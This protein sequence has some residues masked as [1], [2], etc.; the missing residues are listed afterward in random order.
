[1]RGRPIEPRSFRRPEARTLEVCGK[2]VG[3]K[4]SA[5]APSESLTCTLLSVVRNHLH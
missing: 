1:M 3:M 2:S 5:S 4:G